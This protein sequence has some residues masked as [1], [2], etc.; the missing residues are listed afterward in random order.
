MKKAVVPIIILMFLTSTMYSQNQRS[1]RGK[2]ENL[3]SMFVEEESH[4]KEYN[5]FFAQTLNKTKINTHDEIAFKPTIISIDGNSKRKSY[6]YDDMGNLLL[7]LF[8]ECIN[9]DWTNN[10]RLTYTYDAN[11]NMLTYSYE[12][13]EDSVWVNEQRD[14]YTY[15]PEVN[16]ITKLSEYFGGIELDKRQYTYVYDEQGNLNMAI[17]EI[18]SNN[19]W[20]RQ[21]RELYTYDVHGNR[22]TRL[23]QD[24]WGINNWQYTF[25]Y[26]EDGNMLTELHGD[27]SFNVLVNTMR[28][29]YTYDSQGDP[30]TKLYECFSYNVWRNS[31]RN[32]YTYD[33]DGNMLTEL[34]EIHYNTGW[35]NRLRTTYTYDEDGNM[36]TKL[37]EDWPYNAW[38]NSALYTYTFDENNN[39]I[40]GK[41][42]FWYNNAWVIGSNDMRLYYNNKNDYIR[43]YGYN[44]TVAYTQFTDVKDELK[45][46]L[47]FTLSQNYPNP[48]NPSTSIN[49]TLPNSEFVTLKI[50]DILGKEVT[51]LINEELNSGSYTKIWDG[52]NLS[53]GVYFYKLQAGKFSETKKMV[54]VR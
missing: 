1:L 25:T 39:A 11:G 34:T 10:S 27:W 35:E 43:I 40:T 37:E 45:N 23:A 42:E 7:R 51:T 2:H 38:E 36:L 33:E 20:V 17:G 15:D 22:L 13:W 3:N 24:G 21:W 26:D 31:S 32:T 48:F 49:F 9:G 18:W 12:I 8:E 19:K 47:V 30:L 4:N 50:Y 44:C 16:T 28:W 53:S 6:K 54:L 29:T 46:S 52:R 41:C 14:T 5:L